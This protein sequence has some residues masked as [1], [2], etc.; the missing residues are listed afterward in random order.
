VVFLV[1][2]RW[3]SGVEKRCALTMGH[4]RSPFAYFL[5]RKWLW[6]VVGFIEEEGFLEG[7]EREVVCA[8]ECKYLVWPFVVEV[9]AE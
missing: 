7:V 4:I 3:R 5:L 1:K 6:R 9:E 2:A 8:G